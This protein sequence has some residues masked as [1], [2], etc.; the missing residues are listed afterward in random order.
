MLLLLPDGRLS[1][2]PDD[3]WVRVCGVEVS[4]PE[5]D[6]PYLDLAL[7]AWNNLCQL[8]DL[9]LRDLSGPA[10]RVSALAVRETGSHTWYVAT[11]DFRSLK[12]LYKVLA[13]QPGDFYSRDPERRRAAAVGVPPGGVAGALR[14]RGRSNDE[15]GRRVSEQDPGPPGDAGARTRTCTRSDSAESGIGRADS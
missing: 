3:P 10:A 2:P 11:S 14:P 5:V 15:V 8:R 12:V 4:L 1:G 9:N 13:N 7:P 6:H